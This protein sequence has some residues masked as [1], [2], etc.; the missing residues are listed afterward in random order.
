MQ[1]NYLPWLRCEYE[2][3]LDVLFQMKLQSHHQTTDVELN[4]L[5][6]DLRTLQVSTHNYVFHTQYVDS[7]Y[8]FKIVFL[9]SFVICVPLER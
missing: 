5:K 6:E 8:A 4:K 3:V 7:L 1:Y 2:L 9:C